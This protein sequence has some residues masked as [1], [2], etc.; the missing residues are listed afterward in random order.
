MKKIYEGLVICGLCMGCV[1]LSACS[2]QVA[3]EEQNVV[4]EREEQDGVQ[5]KIPV[6]MPR[7]TVVDYQGSLWLRTQEYQYA[8]TREQ[9][10]LNYQIFIQ[11][12][13]GEKVQEIIYSYDL[14]GDT[15]VLAGIEPK[16]VNQDG[17]EDILLL[18]GGHGNVG[19]FWACY[20]FDEVLEQ[21]VYIEGFEE[22]PGVEIEEEIRSYYYEG[23]GSYYRL[24]QYVIE[25]NK[26]VLEGRLKQELREQD[27]GPYISCD[28][29]HYEAGKLVYV[30]R[31]IQ[32]SEID[33]DFWEQDIGWGLELEEESVSMEKPENPYQEV[34]DIYY[35]VL[36]D[37]QISGGEAFAVPD[38]GY[39]F[40]IS[41]FN[42]YW[43][44]ESAENI[45]SKEGY[46][47]LD[48]DGNGVEELLIGWIGE[49]FWNMTEGYVFAIYTLVEGKPVL[50]IEGWERCLYVVGED[51]YLY[52]SGSYSSWENYYT[53]CRFNPEYE[54]YLEPVKEIYSYMGVNGEQDWKYKG[55]P[56]ED[57]AAESMDGEAARG[58]G[59]EW[60]NG[61]RRLE[62]TLFREY[63]QIP[64]SKK[65]IHNM[66]QQ[67]STTT[68]NFELCA[69]YSIFEFHAVLFQTG[70][71]AACLKRL[72]GFCVDS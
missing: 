62:Y 37:R 11:N 15:P 57:S 7:E 46:A 8:A 67:F 3:A 64:K 19:A 43:S 22:L 9:D 2:G 14:Q 26:L 71:G 21:Y 53:K 12:S 23:G 35:Q 29:E 49:E 41:V 16:D 31:D 42:P 24:E 63:G 54:D 60:M 40:A 59:E 34:L 50:A 68:K 55:K 20:I 58:L 13:G 33:M 65:S 4:A 47:F 36:Y 39:D 66:L 1:G 69:D 72:C 56:A 5:E 6:E 61:G 28:E 27:F 48:L 38:N 51:G 17:Y 45:L 52:Q 44:W 18:L 10:T 30:K 70:S 25:N 32:V